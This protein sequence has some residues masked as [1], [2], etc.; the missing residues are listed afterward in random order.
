MPPAATVPLEAS[1]QEINIEYPCYQVPFLLLSFTIQP[2]LDH[3][4]NPNPR[5]GWYKG[6]T[7]MV[8]IF[9]DLARIPD[10]DIYFWGWGKESEKRI[11]R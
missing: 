2:H 8:T 1:L 9:P 10:V 4:N 11:F 5:H 6:S 7:L 3:V